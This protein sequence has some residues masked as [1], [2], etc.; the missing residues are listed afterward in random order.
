MPEYRT[1]EHI[2][3]ELLGLMIE[4][5]CDAVSIVWSRTT[6]RKTEIRHEAIGNAYAVE[7]MISEVLD[8]YVAEEPSEEED[9][10]STRD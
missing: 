3:R 1:A 4:D 9:E 6:G 7:G 10:E 5:G 8:R 2:A